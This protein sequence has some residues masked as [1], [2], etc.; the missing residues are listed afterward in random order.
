MKRA[1]SAP[2]GGLRP[3][4][5][6]ETG[7]GAAA[8]RRPATAGA[9]N[10]AAASWAAEA[11][12]RHGVSFTNVDKAYFPATKDHRAF[13]K[14]DVARYYEAVS[15]LMLPHIAKRPMVMRRYPNGITGSS[16]FQKDFQQ[17][18]PEFVRRLQVW[19]ESREATMNFLTVNNLPT[20]LWLVQLG[21]VEM[22]PWLSRVAGSGEAC[23]KPG[24]GGIESPECGLDRPDIMVLDIDPYVRE[25]RLGRRPLDAGGEPGVAAEDYAKAVE[26]ALILHDL[27]KGLGIHSWPKTS[28][29]RGI[30]VYIP[31]EPVENYDGVRAFARTI[32]GRLATDHP[33]LITI[34]Y[35]KGQRAGRVF[36]DYN[37]NVRGKTL[38]AP[39]SLRPT[40]EGT[41]SM[42]LRWKDVPQCDPLDFTLETVPAYIRGRS[43]PWS[44]YR[45][46]NLRK[47]LDAGRGT[48]S[49][50]RSSS[51]AA[52]T[53]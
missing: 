9:E 39:W 22:H 5:K 25:G 15:T 17:S 43:I 31:L 23:A 29:K 20:L 32:A 27:L 26:V 44:D 28:G 36:L 14:I 8:A 4:R 42:P 7:S 21:C 47:V 11:T 33:D 46:Q 2:R 24:P 34:A 37:Q 49:P 45:P 38:A 40:L 41:V 52:R 3:T 48:W 19:S 51:R 18:T 6:A 50:R 16:F 13:S 30:H 1:R 10:G 53:V 12:A 35:D